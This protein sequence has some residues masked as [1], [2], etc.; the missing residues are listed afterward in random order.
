MKTGKGLESGGFLTETG[1]ATASSGSVQIS[2]GASIGRNAGSVRFHGG[3]NTN[4]GAHISFSAGNSVEGT[5][6]GINLSSGESL[7]SKS[8]SVNILTSELLLALV[9]LRGQ[10]CFQQEYQK[11]SVVIFP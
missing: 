10:Y 4:G 9:V 6:G 7:M 8:G 5:G 2:T 3:R 11:A 1:A